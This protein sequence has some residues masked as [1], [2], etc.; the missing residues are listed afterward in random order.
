MENIARQNMK[1]E[2]GNQSQHAVALR[3]KLLRW[4][5]RHRRQLPWRES[6]DPYRIWISEVML[7]QTRVQA[8]IPYYE[9]FLRLFP[10]I[11][12]LAATDEQALLA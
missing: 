2:P 10:S 6:Q 3:R 12:A 5:D 4:Y 7:Q 1:G 9:K 11:Q 8:V